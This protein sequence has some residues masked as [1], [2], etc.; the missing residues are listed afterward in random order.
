MLWVRLSPYAD[1]YGE[2]ELLES[3]QYE[4]GKVVGGD[5]SQKRYS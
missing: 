5:E 1:A 2:S 4:A 3:V